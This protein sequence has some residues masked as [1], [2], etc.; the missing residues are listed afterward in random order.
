[1]V[2]N[3]A[4]YSTLQL[5]ETTSVE[6]VPKWASET[7]KLTHASFEKAKEVYIQEL[8][9]AAVIYKHK[10]TGL[11][12]FS[13]V[14]DTAS[15]REMFFDIVIPTPPFNDCGC[16]HILEHAV[17]EGSKKYPSKDGF[18]LLL[19]GGFQSFVNAFTY[20]DRTSYLFASTNEKDFY[21]TADFYMSAVF[22]PN[23]RHDSRIFRQEAWHYKVAKHNALNVEEDDGVVLHGR[24]I[25]YGGVVYSEMKK[26]YSDPLSRAQDYIY[27]AMYTNSYRFDSGGDPNSIVKLKYP[28]LV[29][30]YETYYGPN[31]ANIYFYGPDDVSKRLNFV[32][33]FLKENGIVTDGVLY[34]S[35]PETAK[36]QL[37]L[38]VYRELD[39]VIRGSFGATGDEREDIILTGWLLDPQDKNSN[40]IHVEGKFKIDSVDALGMEVLEH[41]LM[42]TS[43][44]LL[45]KALVKSGL[46]KKVV[47]SG[48]TNCF[49]QSDFVIGLAGIDCEKH[50]SK[51]NARLIYDDV[52][53]STFKNIV[54]N[55]I[56]KEAINASMN[57]IEFQMRELN[58][59][60][61]PKGLMLVNLVQSQTQYDRDPFAPLYFDSL[62]KQLKGRIAG[63]PSYFQR[64]VAKHF[65]DNKHKVTVHM[66]AMNPDEFEKLSNRSIR[67]ALMQS[68]GTMS[69]TSIDD[70]ES[71]YEQFKTECE[72][73][74]DSKVLDALPTLSLADI[75]SENDIIPTVYY[76]LG[77]PKSYAEAPKIGFGGIPVLC[78]PIESQGI[79]Y[80][81]L[82]ISLED[83]DLDEIKY[84]DIW[85]NMFQESGTYGRSA[86]DMSYHISTH[87]GGLTA[88]FSFMTAANGRK[89][90]K[91]NDAL[92]YIYVRSKALKGKENDMVDIVME[93]LTSCN[94]ANGEKGL[95]IIKRKINQM[96]L[97]VTNSGHRYATRRLMKGFSVADYATEVS[98]GYE[99]LTMLKTEIYPKAENDWS[100]IASK[101]EKIR[102]KLLKSKNLIINVT[103]SPDITKQWLEQG[104]ETLSN[105]FKGVFV[106]PKEGQSG[107]NWVAEVINKGNLHAQNEVIVAPTKVNFVG[108]GGPLF[109]EE[110]IS[111]ADDL[112]LHYIS[113]SYLWKQV[114]MSLGAYGVFCNMSACGDI[115]FMSYAD[116]NFNETLQVYKN[117]PNAIADALKSMDEKQLLRQKIG[118]IGGI[119]KPL[120]V[121]AKGF[122]ALNR[123]IRR[124]TDE[125]RQLYREDILK[126]TVKCF[127]RLRAKMKDTEE[128]HKVCAVVNQTTADALPAAFSKLD[129]IQSNQ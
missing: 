31:T 6:S 76:V 105:K 9:L 2:S 120:T 82:A 57:H 29:K 77:E 20:K 84:M 103:S 102:C 30:F 121:D 80:L 66:E 22:Q 28:E 79:V 38:E 32:D 71:E 33:N 93:M 42:G 87:L 18:A 37:T 56:K 90:S 35:Q 107:S 49:K 41:I 78:H 91:R 19:Q 51:E 96:E 15:G 97:D 106:V 62:I 109:N 128:W 126:A 122:V 117:V 86:E 65:M 44:S 116:P 64:L 69:K 59:G 67:D 118:K 99:Y 10:S 46:G 114:R 72:A 61:Y 26:A 5:S 40:N 63:D 11:S 119:D 123:I 54:K 43:E 8:G 81:D 25:S 7:F 48:L 13:L 23:I 1:M 14:T 125:D 21:I 110:E 68:L 113:S 24:H 129:V 53:M 100:H 111:G 16:P 94:F 36:K 127:D 112:V 124:E 101:L 85:C 70:M 47:G 108:M 88:T 60:S 75:N 104:S 58:P 50:G 4:F 3:R 83:L 34:S 92:G 73:T 17:L 52:L 45:Y 12:V 89:H 115:V 95:E 74:E 27:Q 98:K 55:G 39:G